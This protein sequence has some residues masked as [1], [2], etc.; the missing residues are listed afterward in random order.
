[1]FLA[2]LVVRSKHMSM[3][4][5]P[6]MENYIISQPPQMTDE[7]YAD[8]DV[9]SLREEEMLLHNL[10]NYMFARDNKFSS[11]YEV[12]MQGNFEDWSW[13]N[14]RDDLPGDWVDYPNPSGIVRN[15]FGKDIPIEME[16]LSSDYVQ[17]PA[18]Y[19]I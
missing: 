1:M 14:S 4:D 10:F 3:V 6:A 5:L 19:L 12:Y 18:A 11:Q 8:D 7:E 15:Q 17:Y 13:D 9:R 2:G 16:V